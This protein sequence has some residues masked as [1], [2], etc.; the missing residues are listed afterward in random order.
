MKK[1]KKKKKKKVRRVEMCGVERSGMNVSTW[2]YTFCV[3]CKNILLF[4]SF[5]PV[6]G[7]SQPLM[8]S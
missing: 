3:M 8:P 2:M 5:F 1:K 4:Y 6:F 7:K